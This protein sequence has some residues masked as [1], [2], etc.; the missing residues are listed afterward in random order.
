MRWY[1]D[2][3]YFFGGTFLVNA[4]PYFV[5]GVTGRPFPGPL[6]TPTGHSLSPAWINLLWGAT[7]LA[8]AYL[9]LGR[10]GNFESRRWRHILVAFAG[11]LTMALMLAHAVGRFYGS[12]AL[13][14]FN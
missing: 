2:I 6:A 4:I 5:S 1:N 3:A 12:P 11:G 13:P 7:N 9:L 8:C 14:A 10:T